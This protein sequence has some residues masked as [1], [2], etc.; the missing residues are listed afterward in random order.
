M[1]RSAT[2][3]LALWLAMTVLAPVRADDAWLGQLVMP[4]EGCQLRW[5]DQ[6]LEHDTVNSLPYLVQKVN[7]DWLGVGNRRRG[8]VRVQEVVPLKDAAS[9]YSDL[10]KNGKKS[11]WV[12]T[13]HAIALLHSG[14]ANAAFLEFQEAIRLDPKNALTLNELDAALSDH[15]EAIRRNPEEAEYYSLRGQVWLAKKEFVKAIANYDHAVR[16]D[17]TCVLAFYGPGKAQ[18]ELGAIEP[19]IVDFSR[20]LELDPKLAA[21]HNNRGVA[22]RKLGDLEKAIADWACSTVRGSPYDW[23]MQTSSVP[24]ARVCSGT[25]NLLK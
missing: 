19:A 5:G 22:W 12:H 14:N 9:Y 15:S 16:L 21:A 23:A 13:C 24:P 10:I 6:V 3:C 18:A 2:T 4:K 7:G 1:R 8:W 20:A 17:P 11:A 25:G